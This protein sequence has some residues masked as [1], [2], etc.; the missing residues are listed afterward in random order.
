MNNDQNLAHPDLRAIEN[1]KR[2]CRNGSARREIRMR[3]CDTKL[4][5]LTSESHDEISTR[6]LF[7]AQHGFAA[8]ENQVLLLQ[9][10]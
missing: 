2:N 1:L 6:H 10:P 4:K 8:Y 3:K 7:W 5:R 9:D